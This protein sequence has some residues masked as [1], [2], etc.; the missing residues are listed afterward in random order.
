MRLK[1]FPE[2]APGCNSAYGCVAS[3]ARNRDISFTPGFSPVS[4]DD[5]KRENR[6]NGFRICCQANP[7]L[8]PGVN[9]RAFSGSLQ[10]YAG[11]V[12]AMSVEDDEPQDGHEIT[13]QGDK[14]LSCTCVS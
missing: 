11:K 8:N 4:N 12:L 3:K 10:K 7:G 13:T 14:P 1:D 5:K 2:V 9:E 6:F